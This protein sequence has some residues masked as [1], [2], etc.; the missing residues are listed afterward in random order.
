MHLRVSLCCLLASLTISEAE[1][2]LKGT[3]TE[4]AAH[5]QNLPRTVAIVGQS[6]VTLQV[7]EAVVTLMA[8]TEHKSLEQALRLNQQIRTRVAGTFTKAGI[9]IDR[10]QTAK[11]SSIPQYG[12]WSDK[13]KSYRVENAMKVTVREEREF[14][15]LAGIV[16]AEADVRFAGMELQ[17][18]DKQALRTELLGKALDDAAAKRKLY[19]E[20]LGVKLTPTAVVQ[21]VNEEQRPKRFVAVQTVA[22]IPAA[23]SRTVTP[24]S[25]AA[26][27]ASSFG[28]IIFKAELTVEYSLEAK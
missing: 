1:P 10:I 2:E 26:E 21:N 6:E 15:I 7:K 3:P 27:V 14:Q 20:R 12:M 11:F 17:H 13:A 28:E 9:S 18:A 23:G 22:T 24:L 5:L 25:S 16:D 19:E 4:L 8:T